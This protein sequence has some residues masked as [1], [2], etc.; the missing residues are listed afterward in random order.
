MGAGRSKYQAPAV[1]GSLSAKQ[2][3]VKKNVKREFKMEK[4]VLGEGAFSTVR[5]GHLAS[6]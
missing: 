1:P 3:A 4:Q 6:P 5:Q 2:I